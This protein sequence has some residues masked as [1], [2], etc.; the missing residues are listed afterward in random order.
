[1][2]EARG[3]PPA[4]PGPGARGGACGDVLAADAAQGGDGPQAPR[5]QPSAPGPRPRAVRGGP[6]RGGPGGPG[7]CP[8]GSRRPAACPGFRAGRGP[9][10]Q[11]PV[12]GREAPAAPPGRPPS[13]ARPERPGRP[14]GAYALAVRSGP[15]G[16]VA[17]TPSG[18]LPPPWGARPGPEGA[19][20]PPAPGSAAPSGAGPPIT[21]AGCGTLRSGRLP[22]G[23]G[24]RSG[25]GAAPPGG[26]PGVRERPRAPPGGGSP[27]RATGSPLR[28]GQRLRRAVPGG[29]QAPRPGPGGAPGPAPPGGA[30]AVP[31]RSRAATGG[32]GVCLPARGRVPEGAGRLRRAG[33]FVLTDVRTVGT[34]RPCAW[35]VPG[36]ACVS[37]AA[38]R[39]RQRPPQ[40]A[41]VAALRGR[42]QYSTHPTAWVGNVPG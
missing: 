3:A 20:V 38:V 21:P 29:S 24:R 14:G 16:P 30:T 10:R 35:G 23:A 12:R 31:C 26:L 8:P 9:L 27:P 33:A 17:R 34:L 5:P 11:G 7:A 40:S 4:P 15:G 1:M 18:V 41:S 22:P 37:S 36:L 25:D 2:V 13:R 39:V 6:A 32:D 42:P 28:G 19:S